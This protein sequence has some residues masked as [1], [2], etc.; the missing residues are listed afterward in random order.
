M[1]VKLESSTRRWIGLST[2]VKPVSPADEVTP[3][4]SFLE[5][6]TGKIYRWDGEAWRCPE[7]SDLQAEVLQLILAELTQIRELVQLTAG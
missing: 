2:D 5:S 4:S 7:S 3:G 6:D 1:A